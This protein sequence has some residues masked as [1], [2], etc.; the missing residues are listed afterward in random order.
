[1]GGWKGYKSESPPGPITM[2]RGFERFA[3]MVEAWTIFKEQPSKP[4]PN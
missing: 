4:H 2:R 1:L 3:T